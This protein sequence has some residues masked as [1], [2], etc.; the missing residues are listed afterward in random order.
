[1]RTG[2]PGGRPALAIEVRGRLI[3]L[4][5]RAAARLAE[6]V[7]SDNEKIAIQAVALALQFGL[8]KPATVDPNGDVVRDSVINVVV[9]TYEK[10]A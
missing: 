1:L 8:G 7:D 10:P 5:P 4:T 3:E 6:L 2:N 9:P